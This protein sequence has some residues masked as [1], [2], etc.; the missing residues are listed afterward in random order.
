MYLPNPPELG[1]LFNHQRLV[2]EICPICRWRFWYYRECLVIM[3][4]WRGPELYKNVH[5]MEEGWSKIKHYSNLSQKENM[6]TW[7]SFNMHPHI[8]SIRL[9]SSNQCQGFSSLITAIIFML[10][11]NINLFD[12]HL[13]TFLTEFY[14]SKWIKPITVLSKIHSCNH[15]FSNYVQSTSSKKYLNVPKFQTNS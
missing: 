6:N 5:S 9:T 4:S 15:S 12:I 14:I 13:K 11:L 2:F 1:I 10:F 3:W 8:L 7:P